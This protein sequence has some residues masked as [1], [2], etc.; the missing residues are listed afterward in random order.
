MDTITAIQT[1]R[2]IRKFQTEK[3]PDDLIETWLKCG[4]QAPSAGNEQPWHFIVIND[5]DLL[6]EIPTFHNHAQMLKSAA[7]A[8]LICMD[9]AL[10]KHD[11]MAIQDCAAATQNILLAV[12]NQGYGAVWLGVY[13]RKQRMEGL[14]R[15]LKIP[16]NIIPFSLIAIGKPSEE[17]KQEFRYNE[18][19][20]HYDK[21]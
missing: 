11:E 2:S 8:I 10:E 14:Q 1:R 17:K 5:K 3:I 21:W 4:M 6:H 12:H 15:L 13:P 19:R 18:Q 16:M 20:I 9:P 7:L